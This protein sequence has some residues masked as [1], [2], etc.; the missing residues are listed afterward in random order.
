MCFLGTVCKAGFIWK[1][2]SFSYPHIKKRPSFFRRGEIR[3]WI[4]PKFGKLNRIPC[5]IVSIFCVPF[6]TGIV[7]PTEQAA[8]RVPDSFTSSTDRPA[9]GWFRAV[10]VKRGERQPDCYWRCYRS[11]W[12]CHCCSRS[13][14][15]YYCCQANGATSP[16]NRAP[17]YSRPIVWNSQDGN[18]FLSLVI[19]APARFWQPVAKKDICSYCR[20]RI[21]PCSQARKDMYARSLSDVIALCWYPS[22]S[23]TASLFLP[24]TNVSLARYRFSITS[25]D[26]FCIRVTKVNRKCLGD[27]CVTVIT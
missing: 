14:R 11:D 10:E 18:R 15:Y 22:L 26:R 19:H 16:Y 6:S 1:S 9:W 3:V 13:R 8:E 7:F 2:Y 12:C 24:L 5:I 23:L 20:G 17:R 25:S 27:F 4:S 21:H